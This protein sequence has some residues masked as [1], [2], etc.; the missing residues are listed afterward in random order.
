MYNTWGQ[1]FKTSKQQGVFWF[2][3]FATQI[4]QIMWLWTRLQ[5]RSYVITLPHIQYFKPTGLQSLSIP[6]KTQEG[7]GFPFTFPE[8][9]FVLQNVVNQHNHA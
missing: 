7:F 6:H 8:E 2:Q 1:S 5:Y 9:G 4:S 3:Y